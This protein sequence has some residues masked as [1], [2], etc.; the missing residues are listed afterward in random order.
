LAILLKRSA[1]SFS[2]FLKRGL[3]C[4]AFSIAS[5][6]RVVNGLVISGS[7][8]FSEA[9]FEKVLKASASFL[10]VLKRAF[11]NPFLNADFIPLPVNMRNVVLTLSLKL[12]LWKNSLNF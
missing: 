1:T 4:C 5:R 12:V 11:L 3:L 10:K 2:N 9:N 7:R 6:V 8:F